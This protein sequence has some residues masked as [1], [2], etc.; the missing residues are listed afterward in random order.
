[1]RRPRGLAVRHL[2]P[3]PSIESTSLSFSPSNQKSRELDPRVAC[4]FKDE[5]AKLSVHP[6]YLFRASFR[7]GHENKYYE[8]CVAMY[9]QRIK[10]R[11]MI[12]RAHSHHSIS[13]QQKKLQDME[14]MREH[15]LLFTKREK[16]FFLYNG[17]LVASFLATYGLLD[18]V[19]PP[20]SRYV[21]QDFSRAIPFIGTS[22]LSEPVV[23]YRL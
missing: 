22:E 14:V 17:S 15:L 16:D 11:N 3:N 19:H 8:F 5:V 7:V 10:I 2:H 12:S 4:M 20:P 6:W 23:F 9:E 13:S 1:M 21:P 18:R